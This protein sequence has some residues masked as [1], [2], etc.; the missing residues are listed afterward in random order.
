MRPDFYDRDQDL[1]LFQPL[2]KQ[3]CLPADLGSNCGNLSNMF[4]LHCQNQIVISCHLSSELTSGMSFK[5]YAMISGN[6]CR[7]RIC[8][9]F[10]QTMNTCRF[11]FTPGRRLR[12]KRSPM[13]E[14]ANVA[15]TNHRVEL[16]FSWAMF[17]STVKSL[18]GHAP[19]KS[20]VPAEKSHGSNE[21]AAR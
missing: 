10:Y 19:R 18:S 15:G 3:H 12:S 5:R 8:R 1:F 4:R 14:T 9:V 17:E 20:S 13:G 16:N 2:P 6:I 11:D 21:P 7:C